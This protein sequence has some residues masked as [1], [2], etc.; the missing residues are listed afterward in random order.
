MAKNKEKKENPL[1][2]AILSL[3]CA[4][5][6]FA[7]SGRFDLQLFYVVTIP[8]K[9]A[10]PILGVLLLLVSISKFKEWFTARKNRN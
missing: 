1:L 4:I 7:L 6:F 10:F 9:I 2:V 8:G 5:V 3:F